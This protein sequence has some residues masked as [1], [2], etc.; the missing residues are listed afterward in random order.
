MRSSSRTHG[1]QRRLRARAAWSSSAL[2]CSA[3]GG[4]RAGGR[5]STV[6][7][8]PPWRGPRPLSSECVTVLSLD[9]HPAAWSLSLRAR[10][11][12]HFAAAA[13]RHS[14]ALCGRFGGLGLLPRCTPAAVVRIPLLQPSTGSRMDFGLATTGGHSTQRRVRSW[15]FPVATSALEPGVSTRVPPRCAQTLVTPACRRERTES[16]RFA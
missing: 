9:G 7:A 15:R 12:G 16:P 2:P 3:T 14:G 5:S 6:H 11:R 13:G 8:P 10:V 1:A 4:H